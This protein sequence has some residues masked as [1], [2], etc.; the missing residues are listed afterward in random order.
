[1]CI[2]DSFTLKHINGWKRRTVIAKII[3]LVS[4]AKTSAELWTRNGKWLP[5]TVEYSTDKTDTWSQRQEYFKS[6]H[7]ANSHS[8]IAHQVKD[9]T[10]A[11]IRKRYHSGLTQRVVHLFVRMYSLLPQQN[12]VTDHQKKPI[13]H[14]IQTEGFINHVEIDFG[15]QKLAMSL[16]RTKTHTGTHLTKYSWMIPHKGKHSIKV[17]TELE[18]LFYMFGFPKT[19]RSDN[20]AEF[21]K[22][23]WQNSIIAQHNWFV[24][25]APRKL[26][27]QGQ[28]EARKQ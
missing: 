27:T 11:Y 16:S 15:F 13:R 28:A 21:K 4:T 22:K 20:G 6:F 7:F 25:D 3:L 10:E 8:A 26:F 23:T 14:L 17:V 2:E 5:V 9:N 1:M 12:S 19:L 18:K 24:H